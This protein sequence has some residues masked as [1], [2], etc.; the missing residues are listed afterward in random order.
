MYTD[1]HAPGEQA[2]EGDSRIYKSGAILRKYSIDELPQ[3]LNVLK[4]EM[5]I[6]GPR[7]H[8]PEHNSSWEIHYRPY[9]V[10]SMVRPGITGLA[11]TRGLRG[12]V[13]S[14]DEIKERVRCDIEYIENWSLLFDLGLILKTAIQVISPH[15]KAY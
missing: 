9:H 13:C 8:M 12:E 6:V 15:K 10:R 1:N 14:D 3:F 2:K 11:Q 5:S 4:G 7:P